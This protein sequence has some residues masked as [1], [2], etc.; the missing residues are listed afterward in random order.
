MS[1]VPLLNEPSS[2]L[3]PPN[4]AV[5]PKRGKKLALATPILADALMRI[6]SASRISGLLSNSWEGIPA[7]TVGGGFISLPGEALW[8]VPGFRPARTQISFSFSAIC[9]SISKSVPSAADRAA[10][11]RVTCKRETIPAPYL[12]LNR[13][14]VDSKGI[15]AGVGYR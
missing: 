14:Y 1:A 7:G 2:V 9:R 8:T 3:T 11:A 13:V 6:S 5:N 15:M 4:S 10:S 12:S